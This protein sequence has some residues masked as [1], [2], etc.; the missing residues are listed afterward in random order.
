MGIWLWAPV[1]GKDPCHRFHHL[2]D[3]VATMVRAC[4]YMT[5]LNKFPN[6]P[7]CTL[8]RKRRQLV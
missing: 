6:L 2:H 1:P 4:R 3:G 8:K 7:N 5:R